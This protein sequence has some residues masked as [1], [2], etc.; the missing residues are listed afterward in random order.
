MFTRPD[1]TY[2]FAR[3]RRPW[4]PVIFGLADE[5]LPVFKGAIEVVAALA[6]HGF[7]ETDPDQGANFMLFVLRDWAE[8][9]ESAEI[10]ALIP[11][12]AD[13]LPRLIAQDAGAYRLFRFEPDGA[14]R[15]CFAFLRIGADGEGPSA[16]ALALDQAVRAVLPWADGALATTLAE[17]GTGLVVHP[18][19]AGVIRAAYDPVMPD[20]AR[21]P[22]HALRLAAR[23]GA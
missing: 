20:V 21:D 2:A 13:V 8:L 6:G 3:W 10:A 1:G 15:A 23:L 18:H 4:V 19:L 22:S 11:E 16:E 12:L 9:A 17:A 7:A 14:I 5:S